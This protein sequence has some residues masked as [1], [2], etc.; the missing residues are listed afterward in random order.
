M[1]TPVYAQNTITKYDIQPS[2]LVGNFKGKA[3]YDL[4][5]GVM[6]CLGKETIEEKGSL[7][8]LLEILLTETLTPVEKK[9]ILQD[10]YD[11]TVANQEKEGVALMCNLADLIE[12]KGIE[13]G[14]M[15]M[16]QNMYKS[17]L[18]IEEI[19]EI[20]NLSIDKIKEILEL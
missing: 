14:R 3:R 9:N 17:N 7:L 6:I 15:E 20:A 8:R 19:S 13:K 12:E 4:M 1:N 10:E 2:P 18:S 11:I 5:T 16:I